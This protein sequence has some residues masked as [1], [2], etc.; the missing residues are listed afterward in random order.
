MEEKERED[1]ETGGKTL[2]GRFGKVNKS[3][4]RQMGLRE[5][6]GEEMDIDGLQRI[7]ERH[8]S[9]STCELGYRGIG[10][11]ERRQRLG[12]SEEGCY[13]IV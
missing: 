12:D 5:E 2:V 6:E 1:R 8:F 9:R 13:I 7:M 4:R 11:S 10:E 3:K